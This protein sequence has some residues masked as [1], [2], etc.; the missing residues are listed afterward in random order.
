[1]AKLPVPDVGISSYQNTESGTEFTPI[2][3]R[4]IHWANRGDERKQLTVRLGH[5]YLAMMVGYGPTS[6]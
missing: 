3:Y 1:M 5:F 6:I 4:A 2:E